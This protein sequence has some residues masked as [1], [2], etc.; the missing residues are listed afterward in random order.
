[1]MVT[2]T[3]LEHYDDMTLI[4]DVAGGVDGHPREVLDLLGIPGQQSKIL[5][6]KNGKIIELM[7]LCE[8]KKKPVEVDVSTI[9]N[10]VK[11]VSPLSI[12][13]THLHL[14]RVMMTMMTMMTMMMMMTMMTM[15]S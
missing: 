15:I 8:I 5:R 11:F 6:E 9:N 14:V 7:A 12:W 10:D 2:C 13:L 4:E 3:Y 1:M